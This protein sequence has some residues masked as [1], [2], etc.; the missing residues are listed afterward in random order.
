[1]N[2][3]RYKITTLATDLEKVF[4]REYGESLEMMRLCK[5]HRDPLLHKDENPVLYINQDDFLGVFTRNANHYFITP[6][7]VF[8]LGTYCNLQA[9]YIIGL[10]LKAIW[11]SYIADMEGIRDWPEAN[12]EKIIRDQ[13]LI[14][15]YIDSFMP[16][17]GEMFKLFKGDTQDPEAG[18]GY[19]TFEFV[20][21][22]LIKS[23]QFLVEIDSLDTFYPD[24]D[25][26]ERKLLFSLSD[27]QRE[28]YFKARDL[29]MIKSDD[30]DDM[31]L[32]LERKKRL[33][34][35]LENDYLETFRVSEMEKANLI[36]RV[37]KYA[38]VLK[39]SGEH[40]DLSLRDVLRKAQKHLLEAESKRNQVRNKIARSRN[41]MQFHFPQGARSKASNEF[42]ESYTQA[43]KTL[44]RKLYH[45]LHS[46]TCPGYESLPPEKQQDIDDLWLQVMKS[47][48]EELYS[49]SPEMMLYSMPDYE[50]LESIYLK[51][52][53]I[54]EINPRDYSL[55]NRLE[56]MIRKG[57]PFDT[58]M[59]FLNTET[60]SLS[61]HLAHLELVQNEYTNEDQAQYH[62]DALFDI[63]AHSEKLNEEISEIKQ[64]IQDLKH[65][66]LAEPGRITM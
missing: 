11:E 49:F 3:D 29:W 23:R 20:F 8:R 37:E 4:R 45:M 6:D 52:C 25:Y 51:A 58:I 22:D 1:M 33:N 46:D 19:D 5:D 50:Q 36:L 60:D 10:M 42:K 35:S 53:K 38:M 54:L 59:D 30:L 64:Q 48:K 2:Q 28:K 61:L 7:Q 44:L 66:I 65:E 47:N 63:D 14:D 17:K 18:I 16:H 41:K 26:T 12:L 40:P 34:L 62:R 15:K 32:L 43:C 31:L 56:F 13:S 24:N 27:K 9:H 39:I 57:S 21:Q 55:G